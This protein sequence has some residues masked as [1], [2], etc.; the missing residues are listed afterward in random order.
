M[1]PRS[2]RRHCVSTLAIVKNKS[3]EKRTKT[4]IFWALKRKQPWK[5]E[6][7]TDVLNNLLRRKRQR[8]LKSSLKLINEPT[9]ELHWSRVVLGGLEI[10]ELEPSLPA[11]KTADPDGCIMY[12]QSIFRSLPL[13]TSFYGT[14]YSNERFSRHM[15]R[16][17]MEH[18]GSMRILHPRDN[19]ASINL[20]YL[21]CLEYNGIEQ[22][23]VFTYQVP[24][25]DAVTAD[26]LTDNHMDV[27]EVITPILTA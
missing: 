5:R 18:A 27:D 10:D 12:F 11:K 23:E 16:Q 19:N 17:K 21:G 15:G 25:V 26:S 3:P 24:L 7:E 13:L 14:D 2:R 9:L 8:V 22:P 4:S 20:F 1:L 6:A